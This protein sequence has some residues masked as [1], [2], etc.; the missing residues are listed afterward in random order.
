VKENPLIAAR[1]QLGELLGEGGEARVFRAHDRQE[2]RA[3][4]VRLPNHSRPPV[5]PSRLPEFHPAWVTLLGAG[6]DSHAGPYQV[7]ELLDGET[8]RAKIGR[9]P[10]DPEAWLAFARQSFAAID[11][12]HEA[13]WIHGDLHAENFFQIAGPPRSWKLL[14][15]P[16]LNFAP[17][18]E[19]SALFGSIHTL[20]PEQVRGLAAGAA[21]DWYALGCLY[22]Y[23]AAAEYP[24][25]GANSR[26]IIVSRLR[27]PPV[28]LAEKAPGL[29]AAC[30]AWV[31]ELLADEPERRLAS[32]AAARQLLAIA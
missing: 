8:L 29:P 30:S 23:A 21:S 18:P 28:S 16:F 4:A 24:H 27:F 2:A 7:F 14:E 1:Y 13:G 5:T 15:L 6:H 11:A 26:E 20:A 32:I 22:Y 17:P 19:R 9:G 10:L 25:P 3:V 31:M 12:L